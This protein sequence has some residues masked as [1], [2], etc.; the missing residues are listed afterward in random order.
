MKLYY[1]HTLNTVAIDIF[2]ELHWYDYIQSLELV[3]AELE[4]YKRFK[5]LNKTHLDQIDK[6][7]EGHNIYVSLRQTDSWSDEKK[8]KFKVYYEQIYMND[9]QP[10]DI[11]KKR[12]YQDI[13]LLGNE[14]SGDAIYNK[15]KD[16]IEK[17][18]QHA[19]NKVYQIEEYEAFYKDLKLIMEKH[20]VSEKAL[21]AITKR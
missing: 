15:L 5:R 18:K 3:L 21:Y 12:E 1:E 2:N 17:R 6:A 20:E 16:T 11:R 8:Y 14:L 4:K 19:K 9:Y 10:N 13:N 7:L